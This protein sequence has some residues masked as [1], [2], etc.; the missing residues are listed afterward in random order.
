MGGGGADEGLVSVVR[1][2]DQNLVNCMSGEDDQEE[3][4]TGNHIL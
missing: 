2:G 1:K 3:E 4:G